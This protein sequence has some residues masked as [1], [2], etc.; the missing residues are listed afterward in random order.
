MTTIATVLIPAFNEEDDIE[1]CL[2]CVARQSVGADALDVLL[3]DGQSTDR[4]VARATGFAAAAGFASFRV[5][6]NA[7]RRTAA[8]LS[9]GLDLVTTPLVVRVDARSRI[10]PSYVVGIRDVL[11]SRPEVGVVGGAQVPLDRETSTVASGIARALSNRLTTGLSRYRRSPISG[12]ADTVWMGA[13]RAGDLRKVGGWDRDHGINED[14]ELNARF[15]DAGYVIWFE[16]SLRSGYVPRRDLP[17]LARQYYSFGESKGQAWAGGRRPAPRQ[18]ALLAIPLVG[19]FVALLSI[20]RAG[21]LPTAAVGVAALL[22]VDGVGGP[23]G[24]VPL[25]TRAASAAA[26]VTFSGAWFAG[27]VGGWFRSRVP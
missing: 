2:E 5:V 7:A 1:E 11:D 23:P 10:Q 15:A 17:A 13:F 4:T 22:A 26:T 24:P 6:E 8:G 20:R 14:Y 12:P 18:V 9:L 21:L 27:V 25:T 16:A 3:I 19:G